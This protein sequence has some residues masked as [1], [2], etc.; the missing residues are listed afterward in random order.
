VVHSAAVAMRIE[1]AQRALAR[2]RVPHHRCG[3]GLIDRVVQPGSSADRSAGVC[4]RDASSVM[5]RRSTAYSAT[6]S[7]RS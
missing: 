4:M 1:R 5:E 6:T 7:A 2:F 3:D